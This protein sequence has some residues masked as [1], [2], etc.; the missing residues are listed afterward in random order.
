MQ[1]L[2]MELNGGDVKMLFKSLYPSF[3]FSLFLVFTTFEWAF[4]GKDAPIDS[5]LIVPDSSI[6]QILT[7]ENGSTVY[8]RILE[9]RG[10][11]IRFGDGSTE[12]TVKISAIK[13]IQSFPAASFKK[14]KYWFP[15]PNATRLFFAPTGRMLKRGEGY[16]SDY[17]LFF[18]GFAYGLTGRLTIGGGMSLFP[19]LGITR[20]MFYVTPKMGVKLVEGV[21][22][23]AG[24]LLFNMHF[25]E[26]E[27]LTAGILYGVATVGSPDASFTTG[28]GYGFANSKF[29]DKPM[30]MIGGESR[31]SRRISLLTENW[32][33]PGVDH[34]L[35]SYGCR[36]FGEKLS[37]DLAMIALIEEKIVFPGIP[38]VGFVF[39]F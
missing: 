7:L 28:L 12:M 26:D 5:L 8:G 32:I 23:A 29:A 25:E 38:F 24:A 17:Y 27:G 19:G 14:G 35:L 1:L 16:F 30:V 10:D 4:A 31:V 37:I 3:I 2:G 6:M 13:S 20:Q 9:I 39:N 22:M 21:D 15:N 33:M 34:P 36:F 11:E 18:P